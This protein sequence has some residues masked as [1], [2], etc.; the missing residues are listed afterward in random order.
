M[1][2]FRAAAPSFALNK[3]VSMVQS[4]GRDLRL[5]RSLSVEDVERISQRPV[6]FGAFH[7]VEAADGLPIEVIDWHGDDVVTTDDA[8]LRQS[9]FG[10]YL[11]FGANA[12]SGAGD[13]GAG[14][15]CEHGCRGD[16]REHAN[17]SPPSGRTQVS[18]SR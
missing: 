15:C 3:W 11:D 18:R 14:D 5:G 4:I 8:R 2:N 13:R 16:S 9:L 12:A 6:E 7:L 1:T 17:R 10:T